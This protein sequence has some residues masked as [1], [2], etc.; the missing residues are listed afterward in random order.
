MY[1]KSEVNHALYEIN[2][3]KSKQALESL[4]TWVSGTTVLPLKS[5]FR[6]VRIRNKS[7]VVKLEKF[8]VGFVVGNEKILR[9][10]DKRKNYLYHGGLYY[11]PFNIPGVI[12]SQ[13]NTGSGS[14]S[15]NLHVDPMLQFP[16]N[17]RML[18]RPEIDMVDSLYHLVGKKRY[19][20]FP[21]TGQGGLT[22]FGGMGVYSYARDGSGYGMG[23]PYGFV[24]E[25]DGYRI[26]CGMDSIGNM[27]LYM[28]EGPLPATAADALNGA[29]ACVLWTRGL[30]DAGWL[31]NELGLHDPE[32]S[33]IPVDRVASPG[34]VYHHA[35]GVYLMDALK[36][37]VHGFDFEGIE[38]RTPEDDIWERY[39]D[40][41]VS[42]L[43]LMGLVTK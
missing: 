25:E 32:A 4:T 23:T 7:G 43:D 40:S 13:Y 41:H 39:Q 26:L 16:I 1:T 30:L 6:L 20:Y 36:S 38:V 5:C 28:K 12:W 35:C 3:R 22:Y 29:G 21:A 33:P 15:K 31:G 34:D 42:K 10:P 14:V 2:R 18:E 11:E 24:K 19:M 37:N 27:P 17:L 9:G 8:T